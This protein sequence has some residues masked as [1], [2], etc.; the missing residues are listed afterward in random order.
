[1]ERNVNTERLVVLRHGACDGCPQLAEAQRLAELRASEIAHLERE[2]EALR[3]KVAGEAV[4]SSAVTTS[5]VKRRLFETPSVAEL[6]LA[7]DRRS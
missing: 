5:R 6:G 7:G 4:A 1:M 2:L 3:R